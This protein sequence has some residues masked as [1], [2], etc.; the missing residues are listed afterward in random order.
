M[1]P[2]STID[3]DSGSGDE[4]PIEHRGEDEIRRG[5]GTLTSPEDVPIWSPAFNFV[6]LRMT[7]A[8]SRNPETYLSRIRLGNRNINEF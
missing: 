3:L 1:A 7:N 6:K 5:T 8:T 2:S 4:I